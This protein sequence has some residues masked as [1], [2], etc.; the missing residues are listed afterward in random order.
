MLW[1]M[2]LSAGERGLF[3]RTALSFFMSVSLVI[4]FGSLF[5]AG[6]R[7]FQGKG[8]P[9]RTDGPP[10]HLKTKLGTPTMGG[11]LIL[12]AMMVSTLLF[13]RLSDPYVWFLWIILSVYG[14]LG[15]IDD[16]LKIIKQNSQG[17]VG[18]IKL[19]V[20][21]F[22]ACCVMGGLYCVEGEI[23]ATFLK[24]YIPLDYVLYGMGLYFV[25]GCFVIVGAGNAVNLTDGLDGLAASQCIVVTSFFIIFMIFVVRDDVLIYTP[26]LFFLKDKFK[27]LM[28]MGAAFVGGL[29][30]FLWFNGS[31]AQIFMGDTGALAA[32]GFI[33]MLSVLLRM[34]ILLAFVGFIFVCEAISVMIQ[35]FY[36]QRTKKRFFRMAPLHH[37]FECQ[38]LA[39][40]KIVM[41]FGIVTFMLGFVAISV[42]VI[43]F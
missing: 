25:V 37:H 41:R 31:P 27:E 43:I 18:K 3:L 16:L 24:S 13:V 39:E 1:E 2:F 19:A 14:A 4:G 32:G 10:T 36:Y 28:V 38:G 42:L 26:D 11:L 40:T 15:A 21:F 17:V 22:T 12:G 30:G 35:T 5:I 9:I 8:Q 7:I 33:G 6:M 20:Q 23:Y 34:E 29:I